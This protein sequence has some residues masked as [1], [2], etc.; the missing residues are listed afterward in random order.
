MIA[1]L[2]NCLSIAASARS[3]ALSRAGSRT[4]TAG[5]AWPPDPRL[6]ASRPPVPWVVVAGAGLACPDVEL[7]AEVPPLVPGVPGL[8]L[9]ALAMLQRAPTRWGPGR[10]ANHRRSACRPARGQ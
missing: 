10:A 4:G 8:S 2:P 1:P 6:A 7:P 3:M 5:L 9:L